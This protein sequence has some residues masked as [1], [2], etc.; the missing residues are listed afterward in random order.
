MASQNAQRDKITANCEVLQG[1]QSE[2]NALSSSVVVPQGRFELPTTRF[3]T[4]I[5]SGLQLHPHSLNVSRVLSQTELPRPAKI[6]TS[7]II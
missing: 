4:F 1:S 3:Q 7:F 2:Y 5:L 6:E